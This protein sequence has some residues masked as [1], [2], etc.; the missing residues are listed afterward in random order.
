MKINTLII[1]A[2]LLST[3]TLSVNI[4]FAGQSDNKQ[5]AKKTAIS[6]KAVHNVYTA[7]ITKKTQTRK[8]SKSRKA[9]GYPYRMFA[10]HNDNYSDRLISAIQGRNYLLGTDMLYSPYLFAYWKFMQA[11]SLCPEHPRS[12]ILQSKTERPATSVNDDRFTNDNAQTLVFAP[13]KYQSRYTD[14]LFS[15]SVPIPATESLTISPV[16]SYALYTNNAEK[17]EG[18]NRI[19]GKDAE[20]VYGGINL[21]YSF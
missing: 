11:D 7:K 10:L 12:T 2:V 21:M 8:V 4:G 5:S 6:S 3:M 16:I 18:K 9:T 15:L 19:I 20:I 1:S 14:G 13:Y 17:S